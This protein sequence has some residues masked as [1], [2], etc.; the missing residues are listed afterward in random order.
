MNNV[1]NSKKSISSESLSVI[2]QKF[3]DKSL[4]KRT[5]SIDFLSEKSIQKKVTLLNFIMKIS[6]K[7]TLF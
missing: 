7:L 1:L 6:M 2:Q 5:Y 3:V 4:I